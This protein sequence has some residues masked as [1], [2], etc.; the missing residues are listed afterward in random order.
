MKKAVERIY[1]AVVFAFLYIPIVVLIV[2]SF[3]ASKSRS[4]WTGFTFDW[5]KRLFSNQTIL[6]SLGNTLIIAVIASVSATII[7]TA[8]AI[9]LFNMKK[10]MRSVVMNITYIPLLN[11]EIV[12]GVSLMLLFVSMNVSFGYLT[13]ILAHITFC[14]PYVI[15][16]VLPKLRQTNRY[17]YES[18]LDLGCNPVQAFIKVV[19]PE[20]M[21]GIITGFLMSLTYSIDDFVISYFTY[22]PTSQTLSIT[23][24][25]M[26]RRK[27]SP[28]VNAL[29]AIIF[30]VVLAILLIM[31]FNDIRK[32][33]KGGADSL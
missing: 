33:K 5:Y 17:L 26:T 15:L 29:S 13:L 31:N 1:M 11:P 22:G 8:A 19:I 18:A 12:T 6:S 9:G 14:I 24:F 25:S 7:G 27:V 28:E 30:V 3:N 21:P 23:I 10:I 2:N 4:V 16:S 32:H 20:I